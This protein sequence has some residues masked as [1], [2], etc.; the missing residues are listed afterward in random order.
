MQSLRFI[1]YLFFILNTR[2]TIGYTCRTL[3][4]MHQKKGGP[5]LS[6]LDSILRLPSQNWKTLKSSGG[7]SQKYQATGITHIG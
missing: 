7:K 4:R 2:I 1:A 3:S 5:L 6:E